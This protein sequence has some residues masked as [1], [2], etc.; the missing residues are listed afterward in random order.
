MQRGNTGLAIEHYNRAISFFVNAKDAINEADARRSVADLQRLAEHFDEAIADY[1]RVLEVYR[2]LKD[3]FGVVEA[4]VGLGRIYLNQ[5]QL[6][7]AA[8]TLGDGFDL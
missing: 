2:A 4:L 8:A 5:R 7:K 1:Q 6:H 3:N